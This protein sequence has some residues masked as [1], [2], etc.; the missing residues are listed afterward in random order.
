[1]S[2]RWLLPALVLAV[3]LAG[4]GQARAD[5]E[6]RVVA[7]AGEQR[8]P[9]DYGSPP[10][11]WRASARDIVELANAQPE[12][13]RA[14]SEHPRAY[15]RA[16]LKARRHWQVSYFDPPT[17]PGARTREVAQVLVRDADLGVV[18]TWTGFRV[19]WPMARGYPGAFGRALNTPWIWLGLCAAFLLPF[20]R[21]PLR[22]LH[23]DLSVLLGLSVSYAFFTAGAVEAS[24]PLAVPPL[25]YLLVRMLALARRRARDPTPEPSPLRLTLPAG[26]LALGV[27]ALLAFRMTLNVTTSTV[28]DVG[29]AGVIGADRLIGGGGLY[30]TFPPDNAHGDTYGPV[31]YYAYV[32]WELLAPW[33]G[34]W[35]ELPAAHAAAASFDVAAAATCWALGRRLGGPDQGLLLAYLWLAFPFTLLTLNTNA[36]D[37]L[38]A[39]LVGLL[40]VALGRPLSRGA[41][42]A[43]AG[44]GKFAPLTLGPLIAT[45]PRASARGAAGSGS[46]FP[47]WRAAARTSAAFVVAAALLLAPVLA[48]DGP[49]VVLERTLGFQAGRDSPFSVWGLY[50]LG[51]GQA[52]ATVAAIGLALGVS[53][54]PRRRDAASA[55]ALAAAV[56][57]SV[58]LALGHWFYT[59]VVWFLPPLLVALLAPYGTD[60]Q[61]GRGR[62]TDSIESARRGRPARMRTALSHGSSSDGS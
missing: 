5:G 49:A 44:L 19:D 53:V 45:H 57:I 22:M 41:A 23:V 58:Q 11:G 4:A 32:P 56:L 40:L 33:S 50:D 36:N 62:R 51:V 20:L 10:R 16:Y 25:A 30:G 59:Y 28:I 18:E 8:S 48:L 52:L 29:Y 27:V 38:T 39:A 7:G 21:R 61:A 12:V 34:R 13:R 14:R 15:P 37:A 17:D 24:V 55:C 31:A 46:D 2:R 42:L 43:L 1:M 6:R 60:A 3:V 54:V 9:S 26:G 47:D 35:D